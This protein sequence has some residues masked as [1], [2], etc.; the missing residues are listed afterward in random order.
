MISVP[1]STEA[2]C[3]RLGRNRG[4]RRGVGGAVGFAAAVGAFSGAGS[5]LVRA[6][7]L[8]RAMAKASVPKNG[9]KKRHFARSENLEKKKKKVKLPLGQLVVFYGLSTLKWSFCCLFLVHNSFA[10][11][12]AFPRWAS[13]HSSAA[14]LP[15]L[16]GR[17]VQLLTETSNNSREDK[18]D[19]DWSRLIIFK[20]NDVWLYGCSFIIMIIL[21]DI[22]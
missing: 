16:W 8:R 17:P 19:Q 15:A 6:T 18:I 21:I 7:S 2:P 11:P 10:E 4:D 9:S 12:G 5:A 3:N 1:S 13:Q 20:K 22:Y 14:I